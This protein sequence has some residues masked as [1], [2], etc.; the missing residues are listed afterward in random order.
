MQGAEPCYHFWKHSPTLQQQ[1]AWSTTPTILPGS[2]P[3]GFAI[4]PETILCSGCQYNFVNR[5]RTKILDGESGRRSLDYVLPPNT[6]GCGANFVFFLAI[7]VFIFV[8][9]NL[10]V[11]H[12]SP[13]NSELDKSAV[14]L[15][16][17]RCF[18]FEKH[19]SR[20]ARKQTCDRWR[21]SR[22]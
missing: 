13:T 22:C 1:H 8:T 20:A 4:G 2:V 21:T 3:H 12:C 15:P 14:L 5:K 16:R 17:I 7:L 19:T 6:G 10:D 18:P 11:V 9:F